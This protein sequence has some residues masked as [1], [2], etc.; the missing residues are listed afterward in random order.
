MNKYFLWLFLICSNSIFAWHWTDLWQTQDQQAEKLLAAGKF[1]EAAHTFQNSDWRNVSLYR[2]GDYKS[3]Y[4]NFRDKNTSDSQYNAGNAAAFS[5]NYQEA[6]DAYDKAITLNPNNQ[7]AI[8]NREIIKKLLKK[9]NKQQSNKDKDNKQNKNQDNK[10]TANNN[11]NNNKQNKDDKSQAQQKN[12]SE[13][14]SKNKD[15]NQKQQP[16]PSQVDKQKQD[17]PQQQPTSASMQQQNEDKN[18]ALRRIV[19]DPGGLLR[20]KFLRDYLRRH[21]EN[22]S[23]G[24]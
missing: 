3:A 11:K 13:N 16:Q 19:D 22:I 21:N 18:Q 5:G 6:I 24:G 15:D 4:E 9:N 2:S 23:Q 1:K 8:T 7:D 12:M 20:Q 10:Q 14:K 17:M